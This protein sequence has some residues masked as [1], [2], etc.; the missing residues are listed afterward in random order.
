VLDSVALTLTKLYPETVAD[1]SAIAKGSW[2]TT[3]FRERTLMSNHDD[4]G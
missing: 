4:P 2:A 3:A 1:L